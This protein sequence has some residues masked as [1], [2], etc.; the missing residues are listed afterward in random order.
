MVNPAKEPIDLSRFE[1]QQP[2]N[3]STESGSESNI[4]GSDQVAVEDEDEG[5]G[6]GEG[7]S[8][9]DGGGDSV[10]G[11]EDDE[12]MI[13]SIFPVAIPLGKRA[14]G[15]STAG[16]FDEIQLVDDDG[17]DDKERF[18]DAEQTVQVPPR[19]CCKIPWA[20]FGNDEPTPFIVPPATPPLGELATA[21][22]SSS[23]ASSMPKPPPMD[24]GQVTLEPDSMMNPS[25]ASKVPAVPKSPGPGNRFPCGQCAR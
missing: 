2:C 19:V 9:E 23:P 8:T 12:G 17:I 13:P 3:D 25:D 4:G 10:V 14:R 15:P 7:G 24:P 5:E 18:E 6:E 16:I 1:G 21:P 11:E 20:T 22:S